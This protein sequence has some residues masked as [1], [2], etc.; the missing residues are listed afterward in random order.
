MTPE[1]LAEHWQVS[2]QEA[3]D[4][5]RFINRWYELDVVPVVERGKTM[6][7]GR[8]YAYDPRNKYTL[9][10]SPEKY[11]S[12]EEAVLKWTDYIHRYRLS[13]GQAQQMCSHQGVPTDAYL[14]LKPVAGYDRIARE[15]HLMNASLNR[16]LKERS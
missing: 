13:S 2:V 8:L 16:L 5:S 15:K 12:R 7:Q 6:W 9:M 10:E 11:F 14:A 1:Q 3:E 4:I